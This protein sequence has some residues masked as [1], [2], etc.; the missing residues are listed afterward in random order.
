[1]HIFGT[2]NYHDGFINFA[3]FFGGIPNFE[4]LT[5]EKLRIIVTK[6]KFPQGALEQIIVTVCYYLKIEHN[7]IVHQSFMYRKGRP[8]EKILDVRSNHFFRPLGI[9]VERT[10][11]DTFNLHG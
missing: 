5:L 10:L 8:K 1:M 7:F 11:A 6:N 4:E 3:T 9:F 2:A